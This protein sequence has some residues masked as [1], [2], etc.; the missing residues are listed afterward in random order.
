MMDFRA[1]DVASWLL[2]EADVASQG[3]IFGMHAYSASGAPM[4]HTIPHCMMTM[5]AITPSFG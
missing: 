1:Y 4:M 3:L 5:I 2:C